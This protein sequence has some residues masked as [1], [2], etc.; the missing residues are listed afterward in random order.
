MLI[1]KSVKSVSGKVVVF[2]SDERGRNSVSVFERHAK[3]PVA[4]Y[5]PVSQKESI[6]LTN[7]LSLM[8]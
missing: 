7:K 6:N 5:E 3:E 2:V 8:I 1:A 4:L